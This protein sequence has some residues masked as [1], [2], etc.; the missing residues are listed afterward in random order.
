MTVAE[1]KELLSEIDNLAI[2]VVKVVSAP[3]VVEPPTV[4]IIDGGT[5]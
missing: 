5:F 2:P 1:A 4:R 3:I